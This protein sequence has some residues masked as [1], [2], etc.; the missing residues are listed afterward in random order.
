MDASVPT[1]GSTAS[2]EAK[3]GAVDNKDAT[4]SLLSLAKAS[5]DPSTKT[6]QSEVN[7]SVANGSGNDLSGLK[8]SSGKD[9]SSE[10]FGQAMEYATGVALRTKVLEPVM[11]EFP[12]TSATVM[13]EAPRFLC[14]YSRAELLFLNRPDGI[15]H[16]GSI[17]RVTTLDWRNMAMWWE[18]DKNLSYASEEWNKWWVQRCHVFD[19]GCEMVKLMNESGDTLGVV[20]YE[21]NLVDHHPFG[22]NG[23]IT[24]IR[25]IRVAPT[26]NPEA[27]RRGRIT[28]EA[29]FQAQYK[30]ISSLL[31]SYVLFASLHYGSE[32]VG[33]NCPK[34]EV[35]ENFYEKLM[36]AP[37]GFDKATGRRYYRANAEQRWKL[38]QDSFRRQVKSWLQQRKDT[39][40]TSEIPSTD[41]KR[42]L[43]QSPDGTGPAAKKSKTS[44]SKDEGEE[45]ETS[46]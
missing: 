32:G 27:N 18:G 6:N 1:S 2:G 8:E 41:T 20:Y 10:W 38:L 28:G 11:K 9:A 42:E 13:S 43:A 46:V 29:S 5:Q 44:D 45:N 21:R 40:K 30:G 33:V 36:G 3:D 31:F 37:V 19:A 25:G 4:Q 14:I 15:V 16:Q 12:N 22:S 17:D 34:N 24:L 7:E 39:D 35:A 26:M 23:T